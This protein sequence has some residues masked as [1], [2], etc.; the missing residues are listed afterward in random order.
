[1]KNDIEYERFIVNLDK[2]LIKR[3]NDHVFYLA[4]QGVKK[5]D[6]KNDREVKVNK[7]SLTR[8]VLEKYLDE[9]KHISSTA[10]K[11]ADLLK[12]LEDKY[13]ADDIEDVLINLEKIL[14]KRK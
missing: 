8:E 5:Y 1:M 2:D 12:S 6:E 4:S 3:F 10:P 14:T 13:G 9:V 7:S 11:N